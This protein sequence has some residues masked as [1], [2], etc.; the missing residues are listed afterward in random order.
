MIGIYQDSFIDYLKDKLG[1][2][3]K[4][5]SKNIIVRCPWCEYDKKKDHYHM[6]ISTEAPI[7]HCFHG[8]CDQSG[9]IRKFLKRLEGHD[10]SDTFVDKNQ[11]SLLKKQKEVFVDKEKS[12]IEVQLPT[13]NKDRF[14]DK[15]FYIKKRLRFAPIRSKQIKGLIYDVDK[16]IEMNNIVVD[17]KLFRLRP[18]LQ[19]NFVGFLTEH[20]STVMFRNLDH[21]HDMAFFKLNIQ[22]TNFIDYYKLP[23]NDVKSN[24]IVLSEGIFDIFSEYLFDSLNIKDKVK[25]YASV[26]SS[27]YLSMIQSIIYHDQIFQPDVVILSDRGIPLEQYKKMKHFNKHIINKLTVFYNKAG[28]D[29][30]DTPVVPA[31]FVI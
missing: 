5:T 20:N 13:I 16:F 19:S 8:S 22:Y 2:P 6:Y 14:V 15:D 24:T 9:T 11:F 28:K 31:K 25:L 12:K 30:N 26:L 4:L 21:S 23:G 3:V 1:D 10:I 7:Y 17:E 29:F 27:K 18:Y